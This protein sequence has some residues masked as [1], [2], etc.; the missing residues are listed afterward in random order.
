MKVFLGVCALIAGI[1]IATAS[2][3]PQEHFCPT[4][5]PDPA[6]FSCHANND[7]MGGQGGQD[8]GPCDGGSVYICNN[9]PQC[10][11]C[12]T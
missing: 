12:G 6:D 2:C 8:Q 3:G 1:A 4:T 7:A 10:K 9:T 5:N 11:P